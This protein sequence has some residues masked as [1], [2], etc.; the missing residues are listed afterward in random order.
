MNGMSHF[1][2]NFRFTDQN[3]RSAAFPRDWC[4]W[5]KSL[6]NNIIEAENKCRRRSIMT[7]SHRLGLE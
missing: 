6:L 7:P 1:R 4:D 3:Y 2:L 5:G